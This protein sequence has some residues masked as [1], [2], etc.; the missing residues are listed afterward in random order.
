VTATGGA[1]DSVLWGSPG[2]DTLVTHCGNDILIGGAGADTMI[3]GDGSD[4]YYIDNAGDHAV[5]HADQGI[6]SV[7]VSVSGYTMDDNVEIGLITSDTGMTIY[8][9][10][11]DNWIWAGAGDDTIVGGGGNDFLSGNAGANTLVGGTGNDIYI[12]QSQGMEAAN[13]GADTVYSLVQDYT[14][15]ANVEM[16]AIL[17]TSGATL[18]AN[19]Q[20]N[21]LW[22]GQGDDTLVGGAGNDV[23]NGGAGH[24]IL[25]GGGGSDAFVFQ[26]GESQGDVITD[27]SGTGGQGDQLYFY[28][29]G[30]AEQG[31]HVTQIDA[32]HWEVS[33]ADGSAHQQIVFQNGAT[34]TASDWH[35]A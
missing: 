13:E 24:D 10:S 22:G 33:S 25:T 29:F 14:L 6:D 3:G 19:D 2:D 17:A 1:G 4:L 31:A 11:G 16:G 28:G 26:F 18:R 20:G 15:G 9:S 7:Y 23:L 8:G 30:T 21:W 27:F 32:T 35:F 5:E 34:I 12:I